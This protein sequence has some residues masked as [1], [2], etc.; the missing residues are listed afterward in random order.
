MVIL[1]QSSRTVAGSPIPR[2]VQVPPG[3]TWAQALL[4]IRRPR[5]GRPHGDGGVSPTDEIAMPA[6]Q[7]NGMR[8]TVT[9]RA[10]GCPEPTSSRRV[11]AGLLQPSEGE[12]D[13]QRAG[14]ARG[15]S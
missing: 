1:L 3:W 13:P 14:R 4:P 12:A 9:V 2:W 15:Q 7:G 8:P 6:V 5:C 11:G 10:V